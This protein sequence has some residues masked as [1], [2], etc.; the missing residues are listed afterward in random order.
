MSTFTMSLPVRIALAVGLVSVSAPAV[1][2]YT[3]TTDAVT[4]E[5][6]M[7]TFD[8]VTDLKNSLLK[9]SKDNISKMDTFH[10]ASIWSKVMGYEST[11]S[12]DW[13]SGGLLFGETK[14]E[15]FIA[16]VEHDSEAMRQLMLFFLATLYTPDINESKEGYYEGALMAKNE[17]FKKHL[18]YVSQ[19][20]AILISNPLQ[21]AL[22]Y[23]N[24]TT[25][26]GVDVGSYVLTKAGRSHI[27]SKNFFDTVKYYNHYKEYW[28]ELIFKEG[29]IYW[30]INRGER[31]IFKYVGKNWYQ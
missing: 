1:I 10:S 30:D 18:P 2:K 31:P 7:E 3:N 12:V 16:Q 13:D 24:K 29:T 4:L 8:Y 15:Q 21:A 14:R 17:L 23:R 25:F 20:I 5:E 6:Q 11:R 19:D 27:D 22:A 26:K 9:P 28:V